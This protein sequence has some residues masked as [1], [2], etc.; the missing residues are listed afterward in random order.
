[1]PG[2]DA[3]APRAG[4]DRLLR[5]A[6]IAV[7][8]GGG[9]CA[10]VIRECAR[11]G[12][13]GAIWPV[14]PSRRE[15]AG[16]PVY[17]SVEA[18]PEAPDAAFIGINREATV[19]A[20]RALGRRGA[21]GAVC[22]ASGFREA[23]AELADGGDLEAALLE[24]A[25]GMRLL[26][27]NCYG[28]INALDG[29]ALWPDQHGAVRV[30]RGAAL[31]TQ[32]SN[33]AIN[34]TM[35]RR[36]LPLA[37]VVTA[38][39]QADTDLSEIA[40]GLLADPRV[41]ALGLHIEGIRDLAGFEAMAAEARARGKPVVALKIGRSAAAQ[42]ATVSHTASL[43]GS[44]AGARALLAR[45]GIGQV[46]SLSA[47][48]E[49]L[50]LLHLAGPLGSGRI[51]SMSCSGGEA[52][53]MADS[54]LGTGLEFPPLGAAQ[55]ADLR[56]V[57]GPK[58]ALANPLDYHTYIWGDREKLAACFTAMMEPAL[59]M[60]CLVLDF[61]REDR[62]DA[63]DWAQVIDAVAE[64]RAARGVPMAILASL[65][66]TMPE[67]TAEAIA[68]R[69]IVP[70]CGLAEGL[71]AMAA[72]A[73]IGAAWAA[74]E[75]APL[76]LPGPAAA[77][78]RTLSEAEAKA[79]LAAHG[80]AVPRAQRADSPAAAAAAAAEIGFPVVLKG[81]GI[82]H[83][84]EA[85]AVALG[86]ADAAAVAAAAAR[87]PATRFL[88]EEMVAGTAA[89]L[90]I[91]VVRDP[92]H[93]FV[94]TLGAGGVLTELLRDSVSLLLPAG[95]AEIRAA[96]SGLRIAPLLAGYR[97]K[98]GADLD[99]VVAAALAVQA[100]VG[101]NR[102]RLQEVEVNPLLCG[103]RGAMAADALVRLAAAG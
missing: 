41:T 67:A 49:A 96:L 17:A 3:G 40:R 81:E 94:M 2:A 6:S 10:N 47:L 69:G 54:A 71:A 55:R 8:G 84:T 79:A 74:P 31:I 28:F 60:G 89:E 30:E 15:I 56:A 4:L 34:L 18:L 12:F 22:F 93:G 24:A 82:A 58:V 25:G 59:A 62:C 42:A 101:A 44:D 72:G 50:K 68:A 57:L 87:M 48:L 103:P 99:A 100:Y 37:Y 97:G 73:R 32:S 65:P 80:L 53:L 91:G 1:M 26:G 14:H 27:P 64:A 11:I 13:A 98:P 77:A 75:A 70:F 29:A 20:V 52:S 36:G 38:G 19:A 76:W 5:P 95:A 92:A 7:I 90:L 102:E 39:N 78:S 21:G 88:V 51:A 66:E 61:P 63:A 85:G 86:L 46:E 35:Q 33:I 23:A 43:A 45:L 83:K 9:W 16:L